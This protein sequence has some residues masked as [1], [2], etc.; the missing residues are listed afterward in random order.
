VD[1][2]RP[3]LR[4]LSFLDGIFL[5]VSDRQLN[6]VQIQ[7]NLPFAPGETLGLPSALIHEMGEWMPTLLLQLSRRFTL[8]LNNHLFDIHRWTSNDEVH[9]I[10]QN[11]TGPDRKLNALKVI[12]ESY[13]NRPSLFS[14]N[15][16]VARLGCAAVSELFPRPN[17]V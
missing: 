14:I 7:I 4:P 11:R 12:P 3:P 17:K 13:S 9:V 16:P 2:E 8:Q 15:I 10:G 5:D 1:V 6:V